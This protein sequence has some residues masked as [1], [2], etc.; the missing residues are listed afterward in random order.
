MAAYPVEKNPEFTGPTT[1]I[2]RVLTRCLLVVLFV[3]I[4]IQ[5]NILSDVWG[6]TISA[7]FFLVTALLRELFLNNVEKR[8]RDYFYNV[9]DQIVISNYTAAIFCLISVCVVYAKGAYMFLSIGI[10]LVLV[11]LFMVGAILFAENKKLWLRLFAGAIAIA[12]LWGLLQ[13]HIP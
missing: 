12:S 6:L 8:S 11:V 3:I 13:T 2:M 5:S 1:L 10:F 4:S 7:T 9:H